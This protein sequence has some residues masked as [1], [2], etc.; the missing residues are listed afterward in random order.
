MNKINQCYNHPLSLNKY[1]KS[2]FQNCDKNYEIE[3]FSSNYGKNN[4][5]SLTQNYKTSSNKNSSKSCSLNSSM[6]NEA[7][8]L[9]EFSE[10]FANDHKT[11]TRRQHTARTNLNTIDQPLFRDSTSKFLLKIKIKIQVITRLMNLD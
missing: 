5:R 2:N 6:K 1:K 9:F 10:N 11:N 3:D 8:K 7:L 4:V